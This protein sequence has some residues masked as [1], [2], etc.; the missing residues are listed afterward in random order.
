MEPG[1]D[2]RR[3]GRHGDAGLSHTQSDSTVARRLSPQRDHGHIPRWH[4]DA[5]QGQQSLR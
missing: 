3:I 4:D 1:R 2:S 5:E